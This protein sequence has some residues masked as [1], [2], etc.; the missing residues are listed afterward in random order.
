MTHLL[1]ADRIFGI[2]SQMFIY[3]VVG[4]ASIILG[5][6]KQTRGEGKDEQRPQDDHAGDQTSGSPRS[7][8]SAERRPP[9]P[10][11]PVALPP[12]QRRPERPPERARPVPSP[13]PQRAERGDRRIPEVLSRPQPTRSATRRL[14]PIIAELDETPRAQLAATPAAR[15]TGDAAA[16]R[17]QQS[18]ARLL[19]LLRQRESLQTAFI[20][21]EVLNP[22]L[23]LRDRD[24][25]R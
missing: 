6:I 5:I 8:T 19:A 21:Q 12:P 25:G 16:L 3:L 22:P 2:D 7:E 13:R 17:V 24:A 23:A 15:S 9:E 10:P 14:E 11:S 20:L 4:L 18:R 1:L